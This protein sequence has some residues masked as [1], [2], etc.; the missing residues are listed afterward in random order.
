MMDHLHEVIS[1]TTVLRFNYVMKYY[2]ITVIPI[3]LCG[4]ALCTFK[5]IC[6]KNMLLETEELLPS[7]RLWALRKKLDYTPV[8][9]NTM[10][11]IW[12]ERQIRQ[13]YCIII[14]ITVGLVVSFAIVLAVTLNLSF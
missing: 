1:I 14:A 7:E 10:P 6:N 4:Y 8:S 5:I 3:A 9:S 12:I 2:F 11:D 13:H